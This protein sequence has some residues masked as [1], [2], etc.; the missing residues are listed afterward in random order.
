[1]SPIHVPTSSEGE[2]KMTE[3]L[4]SLVKPYL[5]GK[6]QSSLVVSIPKEVRETLGINASQKLYVKTDEKGRIIYEPI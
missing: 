5:V 1:M 3:Q 6:N 4:V 2:H